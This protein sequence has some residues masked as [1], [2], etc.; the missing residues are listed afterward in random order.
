M[1]RLE[2]FERIAGGEDSFTEFKREVGS[3]DSFAAEL[4]SFANKKGGQIFVGVDDSG[5]VVGAGDPQKTEERIVNIGRNNCVPPMD[6]LVERIATNG[7][8]VL[9]VHIPQRTGRPFENRRGQCF[10]RVGSTKRLASADERARLLEAAGL[11]HFEESPVPRTVTADLDL[12][13]FADY[14]RRVYDVPLDKSVVPLSHIL[15][16][17][18]FTKSDLTGAT[19]L[20]VAGLLLFGIDPQNYLFHSRVS[21]VRWA[22]LEVGE[23]IIDRQEITGRLPQII[24]ATQAFILRNTRLS[25]TIVEAQQED[26]YQ[27]PHP[28]IRE[29]IVNAVAHRDY[30]L[31][32]SQIRIF[33]F[34]DRL[35]VYSP[36]RLPNSVT[37][38]N[39]RTHFSRP[40]NEIVA[41][42][43]LNLGYVNILG[44]GVPRMIRL[45]LQH[46]GKEPDFEVRDDL[47]FVRL[48]ARTNMV[49]KEE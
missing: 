20:S 41:R 37:L 38:D 39:I 4:M 36:G 43:L 32:G 6:V 31:S 2:L 27:Y 42:V 28:A 30:S 10:I 22:G 48:W 35:E 7:K 8:L 26:S 12:E 1:N 47:F 29:A 14:Y 15:E 46:S 23:E 44:S 11:F 24:E 9:V 13:A 19:R 33:I 18:R 5:E 34:D 21:A 17:M 16:N 40:R 49:A 25:T 45:S 3:S